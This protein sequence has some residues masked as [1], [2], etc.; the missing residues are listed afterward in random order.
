MNDKMSD[1]LKKIQKIDEK[2]ID[3]NDGFIDK[4][5]ED[6]QKFNMLHS[7][8]SNEEN[9]S[10]NSDFDKFANDCLEFINYIKQCIENNEVS[11][12][13][14]LRKGNA[15]HYGKY[16]YGIKKDQSIIEMISDED[17]KKLYELMQHEFSSDFVGG[18]KHTFG[19]G[20]SLKPTIGENVIIDINSSSPSDRDWFYEESHKEQKSELPKK[21]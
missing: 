15:I 14:I 2:E 9:K 13:Y 4:C 5:I 19:E 3:S 10:F 18:W 20:W 6:F 7:F 1:I 17:L 21:K 16:D 12:L 11:S 8:D